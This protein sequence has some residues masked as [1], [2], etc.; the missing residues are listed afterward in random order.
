M[1]AL[2]FA[3]GG[4]TFMTDCTIDIVQGN[5]GHGNSAETPIGLADSSP[6]SARRI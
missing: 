2:R 5:I 6:G 1:T 4:H 3:R